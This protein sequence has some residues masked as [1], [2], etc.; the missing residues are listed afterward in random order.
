MIRYSGK[1]MFLLFCLCAVI[2]ASFLYTRIASAAVNDEIAERNRQIQELQQQV[3]QYQQQIDAAR[4][5]AT[6]LQGE[7]T[8]LNAKINQANLQIRS[9]SLSIGQTAIDISTTA[10]QIADATDKI[11]KHKNALSQF[12]QLTY[13]ADQSTLTEVLLNNPSLSGFFNNLNNLQN[14]QDNLQITIQDIKDLRIGLEQ[15]QD[16]LESKKEDLSR[17]QVL[18]E[19]QRQGIQQNKSTKDKL[20]KDTKGQESQYQSLVKKTQTDITRLQQEIVYL[21]QQGVTVEDA[22]KFGNFAAIAAGIRPAFLLAILEIESG[23]GR[24]VGTGNWQDDMVQCYLRLGKPLRAEQEKAAFLK[25]TSSLGL[26][27]NTVKVSAEPNYGC[28]G[29]MGPA[30][31]IPTTWLAY[32]AEVA[33]LTGHNPPS[34][35]S[36]QDSF[37][38]SAIKLARGGAN[39]KTD[40]GERGAAKAY[41]S[42]KTTCTSAICNYY[43]NT[44]MNKAAAIEQNL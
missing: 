13:E 37:T 27:P 18:E 20:L 6:T 35:W 43:A 23:L 28:G 19:V 31:F 14:T 21:R 41:I 15:R 26:D 8:Q 3:E 9:L 34:P 33:R 40:A 5:K 32:E 36:I 1:R 2:L 44:V 11:D 25:I 22:V 30:Q 29:A 7:I 39:L 24:N 4:G 38:A 16:E 10:G 17:L 12:L 42:G